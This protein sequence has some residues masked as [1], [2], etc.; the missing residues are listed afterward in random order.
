MNQ[1]FRARHSQKRAGL[2]PAAGLTINQNAV[3]IAA[4]LGDAYAQ[5]VQNAEFLELM[6]NRGFTVMGISGDEAQSFLSK[7]QQGT[8]W[9][10]HDAGLTK[11]SPEEFGI[12]RPGE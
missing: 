11:A 9:L 6:D 3:R 12:A 1:S 7:W 2:C 5:A 10:L 4:K 8:A